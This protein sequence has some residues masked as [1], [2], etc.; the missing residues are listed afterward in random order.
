MELL[1]F[2]IKTTFFHKDLAKNTYMKQPLGFKYP[3][4]EHKVCH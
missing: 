3:S 4:V 1:Q 2:D